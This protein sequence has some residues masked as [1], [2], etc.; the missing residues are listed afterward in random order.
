[1]QRLLFQIFCRTEQQTPLFQHHQSGV[2][3]FGPMPGAVKQ[4]DVQVFFQLLNHIAERRG[5]LKQRFGSGGKST[6][7]VDSV[8]DKQNVQINAHR[9][10]ISLKVN[11]T[12]VPNSDKQ[13]Q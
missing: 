6:V 9:L 12:V 4:L 5:R 11:L 7:F 3:E 13:N 2:G 8:Q 1:M 10:N